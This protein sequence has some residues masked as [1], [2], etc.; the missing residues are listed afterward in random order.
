MAVSQ[1]HSRYIM[2]QKQQEIVRVEAE[3]AATKNTI[4]TNARTNVIRSEATAAA[5]AVII[6]AKA[7]KESKKL[8]GQGEYQYSKLLEKSQWAQTI[9]AMKIQAMSLKNMKQS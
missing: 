5:D 6:K 7:S 4:D 1:Q 2:L 3:T 8:Q 9:A